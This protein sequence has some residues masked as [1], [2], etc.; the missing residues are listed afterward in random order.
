MPVLEGGGEGIGFG[1]VG[2]ELVDGFSALGCA[3]DEE[4]GFISW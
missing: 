3:C 4:C 1:Q 2:E